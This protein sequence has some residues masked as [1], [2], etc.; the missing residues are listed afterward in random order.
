MTSK[1]RNWVMAILTF[2]VVLVIGSTVTLPAEDD[3]RAERTLTGTPDPVIIA[4]QLGTTTGS[5][6]QLKHEDEDDHDDE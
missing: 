4:D 2:V 1:T 6:D 5:F 3:A